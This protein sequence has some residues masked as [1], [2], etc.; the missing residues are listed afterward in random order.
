MYRRAVR[1]ANELLDWAV[2]TYPQLEAENIPKILGSYVTAAAIFRESG[3]TWYEASGDAAFVMRT[4]IIEK[5]PMINFVKSGFLIR[6]MI[7]AVTYYAVKERFIEFL[8]NASYYLPTV[9]EIKHLVPTI[10]RVPHIS[11]LLVVPSRDADIKKI[12]EVHLHGR[13]TFQT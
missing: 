2:R 4:D 1:A 3:Y 5:Y 13:P 12:L 11:A 9:D 7:G 8:G 10:G 6:K